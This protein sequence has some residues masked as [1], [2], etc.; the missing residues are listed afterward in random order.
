[1]AARA[2]KTTEDATE[3]APRK[4]RQPKPVTDLAT[5]TTA[6]KAAQRRA[7]RAGN[8]YADAAT[9]R[10]AAN[11]ALTEAKATV[12]RFYLELMG[13]APE[14]GA[15]AAFQAAHTHSDGSVDAVDY[16]PNDVG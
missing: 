7:D 11:A 8:A 4:T 14:T 13:E 6:L 3:K 12:Q 2:K 1:M 5:A 10:D 15:E 9:E 16:E